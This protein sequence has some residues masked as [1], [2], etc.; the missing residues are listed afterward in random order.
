MLSKWY[1]Q[2]EINKHPQRVFITVHQE[3]ERKKGVLLRRPNFEVSI[4][5][6]RC[7]ENGGVELYDL[8][9]FTIDRQVEIEVHLERGTYI[10][11]PRTTGCICLRRANLGAFQAVEKVPLLVP[12]SEEQSFRSNVL[13]IPAKTGAEKSTWMQMSTLFESAVEEIFTK[14]DVKHTGVLNYDLFKAFTDTVGR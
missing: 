10:I 14:F 9:D 12:V 7:M 5:I 4:A 6:L 8:K 3:D 1:Y 11:L 13:S 2:V